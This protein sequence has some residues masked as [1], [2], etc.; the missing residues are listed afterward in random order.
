[1]FKDKNEEVKN[2]V[3]CA[4]FYFLLNIIV[5]AF[6]YPAGSMDID[7]LTSYNE[8]VNYKFHNF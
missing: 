4:L 7:F 8:I 1:M 3:N 2:F 6:T 5:L